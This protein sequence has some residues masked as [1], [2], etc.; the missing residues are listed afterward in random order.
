MTDSVD[1]IRPNR[2]TLKIDVSYTDHSHI[3]GRGGHS[4]Q[5]VM[6]E[7]K[8]HVHF[9]DSNRTS[10]TEKSNQVTIA[11]EVSGVELARAKVRELS[12]LVF[13][14]DIP[15]NSLTQIVPDANNPV[16]VMVQEQ[17]NVQVTFRQR[18]KLCQTLAVVKGCEVEWFGLKSA[19]QHLM[20][21][22]CGQDFPVQTTLEISPQH[23]PAILGIGGTNIHLIMQRTGAQI[24]F[25]DASDPNIPQLKRSSIS[26][27]GYL[28][29]VYL[30]RQQI[31][32]CV[33][34]TLMF[35]LRDDI[36][37]S[38]EN[39]N[40]LM[41]KYDV[42]INIRTKPRQEIFWCLIRGLERGATALYEARRA[43]L[44][45]DD[46]PVIANIPSTYLMP[47]IPGV[48][49]RHL[50]LQ[51]QLTSNPCIAAQAVPLIKPPQQNGPS[52]IQQCNSQQAPFQLTPFAYPSQLPQILYAIQ[53]QAGG[54]MLSSSGSNF[55]SPFSGPSN[56]VY[57]GSAPATLAP[58][59]NAFQTQ[60]YPPF[61]PMQQQQQCNNANCY[62]PSF[63][64][65]HHAPLARRISK[66]QIK[67]NYDEGI[68]GCSSGASSDTGT[69][70]TTPTRG[71]QRRLGDSMTS[72]TSISTGIGSSTSINTAIGSST[73]S[74]HNAKSEP[75]ISMQDQRASVN[76]LAA[77]MA[78]VMPDRRAPGC[79]K[80]NIDRAV[81]RVLSSDYQTKKLMSV[82]ALQQKPSPDVTRVP[83]SSW[84]G[85]GLSRSA[86][87]TTLTEALNKM[88]I[89]EQISF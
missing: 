25:P 86:S 21:H 33:P 19:I 50:L 52:L 54:I 63:Q 48:S 38:V 46:P 85:Y 62:P 43:L 75:D 66:T 79:E 35:D 31:I 10:V 47:H 23:H 32:G 64:Q 59:Q 89:K 6:E 22:Y 5:R 24:I 9:P 12:P 8:C 78:E 27:S 4:I 36:D 13:L 70:C 30:A 76:G 18:P 34:M 16:V 83:T 56:I 44:G 69:P 29:Q 49:A 7:T 40:N 39:I 11:G 37:M 20:R 2:V 80:T 51:N 87:Q 82:R 57:L 88:K 3:I 15:M 65:S 61:N 55:I 72:L 84:S 26:I 81:R 45:L 14:F 42:C 53:Q 77:I 41:A 17:F 60:Q 68:G 1:M 58:G 73:N 71:R 67:N 74:I 28:D